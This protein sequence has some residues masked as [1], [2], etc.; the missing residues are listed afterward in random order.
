MLQKG[1]CQMPGGFLGCEEESPLSVI[2]G[3]MLAWEES[4]GWAFFCQFPFVLARTMQHSPSIYNIGATAALFLMLFREPG[5]SG[6]FWFASRRT[7]FQR[8][9]L[10]GLCWSTRPC[11]FVLFLLCRSDSFEESGCVTKGGG[12][13]PL[14]RE[15]GG[16]CPVM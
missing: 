3:G 2:Y 12:G 15:G 1:I 4:W 6:C 11:L 7:L 5:L 10:T 14:G 16:G 13:T 9:N 8:D